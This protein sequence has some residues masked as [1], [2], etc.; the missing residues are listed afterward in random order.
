MR[1]RQIL[2][3]STYSVD[4]PAPF[5]I[6]AAMLAEEKGWN[7]DMLSANADLPTQS[8]TPRS[9]LH[10]RLNSSTGLTAR[11]IMTMQ[12]KL[13]GR[14]LDTN[15]VAF[16][17]CINCLQAAHELDRKKEEPWTYLNH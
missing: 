10:S 6:N 7:Q 5:D 12:A 3:H 9:E 11:E 8:E 13:T 2:G 4:V 17:N 14:W 15:D 16:R 1:G